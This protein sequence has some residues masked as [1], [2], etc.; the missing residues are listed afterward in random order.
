M[1]QQSQGAVNNI[2]NVTTLVLGVA[3]TLIALVMLFVYPQSKAKVYEMTR[4]L[5]RGEGKRIR[6]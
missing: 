5:L 6:G 2:Y 4:T 3:Y 1:L